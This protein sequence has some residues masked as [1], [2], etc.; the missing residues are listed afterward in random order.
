MI[1]HS[2]F[3]YY[4]DNHFWLGM[5]DVVNGDWRWIY[6][7]TNPNFKF[8]YP[9]Y[10]HAAKTST[11][12]NYNCA[13]MAYSYSGKWFDYPCSYTKPYICESNFCKFIIL[14]RR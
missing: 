7:Q 9:G 1:S 2:F 11:S 6:D 10:P 14:F 12:K 5:T 8:W 13:F 4:L 3:C